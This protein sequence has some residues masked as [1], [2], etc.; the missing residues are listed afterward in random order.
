[1]EKFGEWKHVLQINLW[2]ENAKA[3]WDVE[4][5]KAGTY[6]I[7][8]SYSGNGRMVW[9]VETDEGYKIKNQQNSSP[10]YTTFPIGWVNFSKPG[11]HTLSVSLLEGD[12]EKANL[13]GIKISP[14]EF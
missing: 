12:F 10:I 6:L 5:M 9:S 13:T 4:V 14:V 7:E 1:M 3:N 11:K 8:L 2:K